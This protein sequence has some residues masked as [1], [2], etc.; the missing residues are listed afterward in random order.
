[1]SALKVLLGGCLMLPLLA[2]AA[3][4]KVSDLRGLLP[5][6][7][8]IYDG[9]MPRQPIV[10]MTYVDMGLTCMYEATDLSPKPSMDDI[11][12]LKPASLRLIN[13]TK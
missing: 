10:V 9:L 13:C 8:A 2:V 12:R 3:P 4:P 7:V 1:M 11:K 5:Q 6:D